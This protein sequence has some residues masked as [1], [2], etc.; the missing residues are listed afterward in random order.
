MDEK[1]A[2]GKYRVVGLCLALVVAFFMAMTTV[3]N[4]RLKSIP[5]SIVMFYHGLVGA[6]V[7][8]LWILADL[9]FSEKGLRMATYSGKMWLVLLASTLFSAI[10]TT[11]HTVAYQ[12]D[13]SG[14]VVLV[15]NIGT[16]YFFLSDIFIFHEAF[17]ILEL[18]CVLV[19][20]II[21]VTIS[22]FKIR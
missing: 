14:F 8:L 21:I 22:A 5:A 2:N 9:C 4:R 15:G 11:S 6:I 13:S 20:A 18:V 17:S 3:L 12:S 16:V 19:I 1:P 7:I 10:V